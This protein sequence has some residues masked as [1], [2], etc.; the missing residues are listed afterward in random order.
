MVAVLRHAY[1]KKEPLPVSQWKVGARGRKCGLVEGVFACRRWS[2]LPNA[3]W[4]SSTRPISLLVSQQGGLNP[5]SG[6]I[7]GRVTPGFLHVGITPDDAV[8]RRG[9]SGISSSPPP[10][11]F[12]YG[13][14]PYSPQS[15]SSVL[16]TSMAL[17]TVQAGRIASSPVARCKLGE[18]RNLS[19]DRQGFPP[20]LLVIWEMA[21]EPYNRGGKTFWRKVC[22]PR[23]FPFQVSSLERGVYGRVRTKLS[24]AGEH[25]ATCRN[26]A[27][28]KEHLT[29]AKSTRHPSADDEPIMIIA[30]VPRVGGESV[31][32]SDTETGCAQPARSVYLIFSLWAA[33]PIGNISR[34]AV[35]RR[36]QGKFP[37][38]RTAN[39]RRVTPGSKEPWRQFA[40]R[41]PHRFRSTVYVRRIGS[42]VPAGGATCSSGFFGVSGQRRHAP[43]VRFGLA[44][45]E[46]DL[47]PC[48]T[49]VFPRQTVPCKFVRRRLNRGDVTEMSRASQCWPGRFRWLQF[50]S[51]ILFCNGTLV[52]SL[53]E[54][55]WLYRTHNT[56]REVSG[57]H[58]CW[59][60]LSQEGHRLLGA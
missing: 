58:R 18:A 13:A 45:F 29:G 54:D 57:V 53:H 52:A 42:C 10:P 36:T 48:R 5:G 11:A 2:S 6:Q 20:P 26:K 49:V 24:A 46:G 28:S 40:S 23:N 51:N 19:H 17:T 50:P 4:S 22:R 7:P 43:A 32:C 56:G 21:R 37:E 1:G 41:N 9:F 14:A 15:P 35:A 34:H 3:E 60:N 16:K 12:H 47:A 25:Q 38:S 31:E 44:R 59:Q 55:E 30:A 8:G 27:E 33:Q 39:Q